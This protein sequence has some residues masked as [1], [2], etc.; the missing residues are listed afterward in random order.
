M[1]SIRTN[2]RKIDY[3]HFKKIMRNSHY[4]KR[5]LFWIRIKRVATYMPFTCFRLQTHFPAGFGH[6][7]ANVT[8][9]ENFS[10][11]LRT[12]RING[13]HS[14]AKLYVR[15]ER[16]TRMRPV[17]MR[18][19]CQV[20]WCLGQESLTVTCPRMGLV[21]LLSSLSNEGTTSRLQE[22]KLIE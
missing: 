19:C 9:L 2:G 7:S 11:Y 1:I 20:F 15:N 13:S 14:N 16:P 8:W 21:W 12:A 10:Q 6:H 5:L 4:D 3:C 18:T 17:I 22:N